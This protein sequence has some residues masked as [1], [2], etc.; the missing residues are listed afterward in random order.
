M[1]RAVLILFSATVGMFFGYYPVRKAAHLDP[2]E[3]LRYKFSA[4]DRGP[5]MPRPP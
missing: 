2:I 3:V 4:T 5:R 1:G